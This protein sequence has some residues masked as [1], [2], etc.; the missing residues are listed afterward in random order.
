MKKRTLVLGIA[1]ATLAACASN[2]KG[3]RTDPQPQRSAT[4]PKAV[5]ASA[6]AVKPAPAPAAEAKEVKEVKIPPGHMPPAGKCR[7]WHPGKPPGQQPPVGECGTLRARVPAGAVLVEGTAV[8]SVPATNAKPAQVSA[9]KAATVAHVKVP[10]GH[11][12]PKGKC[13]LWYD[14]RSPG[15][16]PAVGECAVLEKNVPQGAVLVRG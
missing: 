14:G 5:V 12:P 4:P 10:A 7:I 13:R 11:M 3:F 8:K 16:Q 9:P 15:K 6:P 1:V 2:Q